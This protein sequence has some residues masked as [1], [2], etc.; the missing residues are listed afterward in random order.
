MHVETSQAAGTPHAKLVFNKY[1]E[2]RIRDAESRG[3]QDLPVR[4]TLNRGTPSTCRMP[5]RHPA[6]VLLIHVV[7][8]QRLRYGQT[9]RQLPLIHVRL[10]LTL[11]SGI[12]SSAHIYARIIFRA[13]VIV[14]PLKRRR[15][16]PESRA[17]CGFQVR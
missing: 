10:N 6:E 14:L 11:A 8:G 5:G 13:G 4:E 15:L 7:L 3:D 2:A 16:P 12:R 9:E 17:A 1:A